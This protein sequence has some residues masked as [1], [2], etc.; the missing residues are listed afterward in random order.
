MTGAVQLL[1]GPGKN[2]ARRHK[3]SVGQPILATLVAA[4]IGKPIP[5]TGY[6][7]PNAAD[8][9]RPEGGAKSTHLA[10]PAGSVYYFECADE[11]AALALAAALNWHGSTSGTRIE[12][13]RSTLMGEKGFG[14][15]VCGT[16]SLHD[17][18]LPGPPES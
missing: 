13:R 14:L 2:F 10:V 15:G 18:D 17:G 8:P 11:P 7:L 1:D 6:A 3:V 5:V 9:D 16:W 12:N 4:I